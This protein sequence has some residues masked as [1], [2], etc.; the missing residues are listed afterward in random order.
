MNHTQRLGFLALASTLVFA[1]AGRQSVDEPATAATAPSQGDA[2]LTS[3]V[4]VV[5]VGEATVIVRP[6]TNPIVHISLFVDH[7]STSWTTEAGASALVLGLSA[8][9][10]GG[11]AGMGR[12]AFLSRL[13]AMGSTI[14]GDANYD[15]S[16]VSMEA[17]G[18]FWTE[19]WDL[20]AATLRDPALGSGEL[21]R[22]RE[23]LVTARRSRFDDPDSAVVEVAREAFFA[24]HPYSA[25]PDGTEAGLETASESEAREALRTLLGEPAH[26][27]VVAVGDVDTQRLTERVA[28]LL[29][30]LTAAGSAAPAEPFAHAQ[31]TVTVLP[32]PDLPTNYIVGYFGAPAPGTTDYAALEIG[33]A[34]LDHRLFEEVRTRRNLTY[35]VSAGL[36]SRRANS[37]YLYVTATDPS[38]TLGVMFDTI[39]A[40]ADTPVSA[41]ELADQ[42]EQYLTGYYMALASNSAQASLLGSWNLLTGDIAAADQHI[43]ELR[44]VTPADVS[45]VIDQYV[46]A[47]QWGVVGNPDSI[48][49]ALFTSR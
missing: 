16:V 45:R 47:I 35:A 37:G 49:E 7:G 1:C 44:N 24:G 43:A 31:S 32:R 18:A 36:G 15:Y 4:E 33:L 40:M 3:G 23:R 34:I 10:D 30:R 17:V 29:D 39:E 48:D 5:R 21:E 19:T 13:D 27:T 2:L 42:L 46:R 11:P 41:Q 22:A 9:A 25:S 26:V 12:D 6:T 20:M 14:A 28:L 8:M 38:T